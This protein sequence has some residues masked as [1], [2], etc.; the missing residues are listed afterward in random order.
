[1]LVLLASLPAALA[2]DL[3]CGDFATQAEAQA[4]LTQGDPNNLDEDDDGIA[5]EDSF[6]G[7][8]TTTTPTSTITATPTAS[9]TATPTTTNAAAAQYSDH[10]GP[11]LPETGGVSALTA[12]VPLTLIVGAG[13]VSLGIF[14]RS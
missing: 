10:K 11:I 12:L 3:N 8:S 2:Q 5:C 9:P 7:G 6:E 1:M 4:A 14:R 13:I